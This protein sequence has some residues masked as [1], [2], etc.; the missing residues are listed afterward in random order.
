MTLLKAFVDGEEEAE[1]INNLN[2]NKVRKLLSYGTLCSNGSVVFKEDKEEH[3]GDPTETA[4]VFA[5][6]KNSQPKD[7]LNEKYPR[8]AE[9]PFDSDRKL[10]IT[11]NRIDDK[12]IVIVKGAF[13]M[14]ADK[15]IGAL[16]VYVSRIVRSEERRVGKEC[17]SRWSPYH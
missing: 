3:I 7:E 11:I 16:N 4:I 8:I 12:N 10:M 17:R 9:I 14:M 13:D 15:C 1:D 2:S 6:H 5:S